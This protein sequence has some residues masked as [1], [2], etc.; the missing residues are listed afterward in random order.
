[1]YWLVQLQDLTISWFSKHTSNAITAFTNYI[2]DVCTNYNQ[3]SCLISHT[4]CTKKV[5][6]LAVV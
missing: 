4:R 6:K 5:W 3:L 1:M 2:K